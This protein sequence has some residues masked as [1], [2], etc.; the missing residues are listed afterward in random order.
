[1]KRKTANRTRKALG[2]FLLYGG[3]CIS[4]YSVFRGYYQQHKIAL[5]IVSAVFTVLGVLAWPKRKSSRTAPPPL[6]LLTLT[7]PVPRWRV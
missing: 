4:L 2:N 3:S 1:M 5:L 6:H 7:L